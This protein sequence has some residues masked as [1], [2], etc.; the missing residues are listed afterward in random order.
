[1]PSSLL[2]DAGSLVVHRVHVE[3]LQARGIDGGELRFDFARVVAYT[4][5]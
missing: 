4:R 5:R 3:P 2:D 1:V